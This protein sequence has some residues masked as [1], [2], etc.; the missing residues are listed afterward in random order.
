M[1]KPN[2]IFGIC[3]HLPPDTPRESFK[4]NFENIYLPLIEFCEENPRFKI[5]LHIGGTV[6]DWL[7]KNKP[8]FFERFKKLV[9]ERKVE[10]ISGG[11]FEPAFSLIPERDIS[12]QI[13]AYA[14]CLKKS[15]GYQPTGAWLAQSVWEGRLAKVLAKGGIEYIILDDSLFIGAKISP[16][17]ICGYYVTESEGETLKVFP[18]S[19]TLACLFQSGPIAEALQSLKNVA[20]DFSEPVS[21]F[22]DSSSQ[23]NVKEI[24]ES[25]KENESFFNFIAPFEYL[26]HAKAK[27]RIYLSSDISS[28]MDLLIRHPEMNDLH[29]KMIYV[30]TK[31]DAAKK[32]V[33][34]GGGVEREKIIKQASF[35]LWKAQNFSAYTEEGFCQGRVRQSAFKSLIASENLIDRLNRGNA[36][37]VDISVTDVD[38]DGNDEAILSN[39]IM[40]IYFS[41]TDGAMFEFDFKPKAINIMNVFEDYK[42]SNQEEK[43]RRAS[44]FVDYLMPLDSKKEDI[45][46]MNSDWSIEKAYS[47][48]AQRRTNEVNIVLASEVEKNEKKIRLVKN[49]WLYAGQSIVN[50]TYEFDNLSDE[51]LNFKFVNEFNLS[52]PQELNFGYLSS[53]KE[54][55]ISLDSDKEVLCKTLKLVD[56]GRRFSVSFDMFDNVNFL[57]F[58]LFAGTKS[59]RGDRIFQGLRIIPGW[60]VS[61][62]PKGKTAY[63]FALRIED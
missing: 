52:L 26:E 23:P 61:I 43:K 30:S 29:K 11:M 14:D 56:E 1:K 13:N 60:N 47:L 28:H 20:Q 16:K 62:K 44:S 32:K 5:C 4:Q 45:K 12:G 53:Q 36:K 31:V 42:G 2:L 58:P 10:M 57:C 55:R 63:S 33:V 3:S 54:S 48:S 21:I 24:L 49:V 50:I 7:E 41:K 8:D 40:N 46:N 17:D 18:N 6:F 35:E 39:E 38:K 37:Y 22:I 51:E 25:F 34:F 9:A 27:G 15:F 59:M 19:A